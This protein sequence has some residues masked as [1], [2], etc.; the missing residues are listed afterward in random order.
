MVIWKDE[1]ILKELFIFYMLHAYLDKT[2][3]WTWNFGNNFGSYILFNFG[4][5]PSVAVSMSHGHHSTNL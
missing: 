5:I 4:V 2:V 1:S 3:S